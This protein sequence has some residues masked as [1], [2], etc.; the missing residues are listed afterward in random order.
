MQTGIWFHVT[1]SHNEEVL[2]RRGILNADRSGYQHAA[3]WADPNAVYV[4]PDEAAARDWVDYRREGGYG[5]RRESRY[6]ILAINARPDE[7][8]VC[9]DNEEFGGFLSAWMGTKN[10]E[11]WPDAEESESADFYQTLRSVSADGVTLEQWLDDD[12]QD[13]YWR[14]FDEI[15]EFGEDADDRIIA[16][17]LVRV[18]P[19]A[20]RA[21]VCEHYA[22]N[23]RALMLLSSVPPSRVIALVP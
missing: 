21:A 8:T 3:R 5:G 10:G 11:S 15:E 22:A 23:G 16:S 6:E 7:V 12:G 14:S 2:R 1:P 18:M 20:L 17:D 9:P 13:T 19:P 4:W